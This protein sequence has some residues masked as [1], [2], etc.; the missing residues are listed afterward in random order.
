M[1]QITIASFQTAAVLTWALPIA[2]LAVVG[3][4][5]AIVFRG[6]GFDEEV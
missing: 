4:Y 5:W 6:R 1:E 2:L 3:I